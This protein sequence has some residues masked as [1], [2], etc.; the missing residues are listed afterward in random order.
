M[1]G[2]GNQRMIS[3]Y[4]TLP[5]RKQCISVLYFA[6]PTDVVAHIIDIVDEAPED[7]SFD[8]LKTTVIGHLSDSQKIQDS[9]IR[10]LHSFLTSSRN[11]ISRW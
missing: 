6:L 4:V 2:F 5:S 10:R 1:P 7:S 11:T 8:T 9:Q 3:K